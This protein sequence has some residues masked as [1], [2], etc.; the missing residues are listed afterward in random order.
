M[1]LVFALVF[2][3]EIVLKVRV[4]YSGDPDFIEVEFQPAHMNYS[5]LLITC[6]KE[7]AINPQMVER[8]R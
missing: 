4:A 1:T 8:I 6:C 2:L 7:L 5:N 3:T